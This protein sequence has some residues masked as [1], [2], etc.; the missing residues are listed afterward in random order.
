MDQGF[1]MKNSGKNYFEN[2]DWKVKVE[3][4]TTDIGKCV[5][6]AWK[7]TDSIQNT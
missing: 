2:F 1:R 3:Y 7:G 5:L 6:K 4:T